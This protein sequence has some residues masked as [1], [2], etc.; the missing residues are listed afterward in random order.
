MTAQ[1]MLKPPSRY[2]LSVADYLVLHEAGAFE[3][4][5]TEL[6][7]GEI[8][9]VSPQAARHIFVK[10]EP[11]YRL[12]RALEELGSDLSVGIHGSVAIDDHS[13]PEPDIFLTDAIGEE[14]YIPVSSVHFAVEVAITSL[15]FDLAGKQRLYALHGVPEY[16]VADVNGRVIHQMWAPAGE[17]YAQRREVGVGEAV[18]AV[19]VEGLRVETSGLS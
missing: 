14:G 13:L 8:I 1:D 17:A 5:R 18:E 6:I 10:S 12:R 7:E 4:M 16:W 9:V 11:S 19:T 15:D 3:G 2:R